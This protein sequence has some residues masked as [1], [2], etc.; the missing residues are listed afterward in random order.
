MLKYV[1]PVVVC[2]ET[3]IRGKDVVTVI[4]LYVQIPGKDSEIHCRTRVF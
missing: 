3:N 1:I 2:V 4:H